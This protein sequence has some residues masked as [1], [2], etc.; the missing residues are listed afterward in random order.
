MFQPLAWPH[1][2]DCEL[3]NNPPCLFDDEPWNGSTGYAFYCSVTTAFFL[4]LLDGY[5][6]SFTWDNSCFTV[7]EDLFFEI[8]T[9]TRVRREYFEL[10]QKSRD[11]NGNSACSNEDPASS[12]FGRIALWR[13]YAGGADGRRSR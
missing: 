9:T 11:N 4:G 1:P 6:H 8:S 7:T 13:L 3:K 2:G 5:P 12:R 10:V